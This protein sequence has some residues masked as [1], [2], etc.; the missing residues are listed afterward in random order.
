MNIGLFFGSF[1]PI[2]IG[3]LIIANFVAD[4]TNVD[5]VWMIVSPHNPFKKT[6]D[7]LEEKVRL[8]LVNTAIT[9]NPKLKVSDIEFDLPRPSYT[10]DTITKIKEKYPDNTFFVII[11]SDSLQTIETWKNS[12]RLLKENF[13]MVYE[14]PLF[15][16]TTSLENVRI[17]NAPLLNICATDIRKA[18]KNG[19]SIRYLVPD[20]VLKEIEEKGYYR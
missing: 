6:A 14:R 15:S 20:Q 3:H 17:L 5:E 16:V 19:K 18:I 12:K 2:H 7:L 9:D 13:F 1:N 8:S 4:D 11:G 10:I